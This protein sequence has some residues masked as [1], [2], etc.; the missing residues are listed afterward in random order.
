MRIEQ[1]RFMS[2]SPVLMMFVVVLDM[3]VNVTDPLE[4]I[5]LVGV[6]KSIDYRYAYF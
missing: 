3:A 1:N 2:C 5:T 6:T 4:I